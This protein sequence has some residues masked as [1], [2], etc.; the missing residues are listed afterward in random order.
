VAARTGPRPWT[1]VTI[2]GSAAHAALELAAGVGLPLASVA[3]PVPAAVGWTAATAAGWRAAGHGGSGPDVALRVV[4]G[5]ALAA[6]A[7]H[8]LGW[9]RR[10]RGLPW[11]VRCEGLEGRVMV[12]YN[13]VLVVTAAG[14]VAGLLRENRSAGRAA[15]LVPLALVPVLVVVQHAEHARL[16]AGARARPAWWN[17]RLARATASAGPLSAR[18]R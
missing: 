3:G 18:G 8:W 10:R 1:R 17:R 9:P 2:A 4:D 5:T 16:L 13:A 12:P 14:A 7:A 15:G 6:V 11:L